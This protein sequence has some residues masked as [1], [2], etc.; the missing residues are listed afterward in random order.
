MLLIRLYLY[1]VSVEYIARQVL[2]IKDNKVNKAL[3]K[4]NK[5]L[6]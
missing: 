1:K 5:N 3:N 2:A 6:G 4:V